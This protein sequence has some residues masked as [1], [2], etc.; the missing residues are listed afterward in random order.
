PRQL[1]E[2]QES[3]A[4]LAFLPP[5]RQEVCQFG[6]LRQSCPGNRL[7]RTLALLEAHSAQPASAPGPRRHSPKS[8]LVQALI[9]AA[10]EEAHRAR[11]V[12]DERAK[13]LDVLAHRGALLRAYEEHAPGGLGRR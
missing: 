1:V 10:W 4:A 13:P 2:P 8:A 6:F 11:S 9:L 12:R 5:R 3:P 7:G